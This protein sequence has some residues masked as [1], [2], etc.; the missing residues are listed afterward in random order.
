MVSKDGIEQSSVPYGQLVYSQ[1]GFHS[2]NLPKLPL[3]SGMLLH[4]LPMPE[5]LP[6]T[7]MGIDNLSSSVVEL[8]YR[9][10]VLAYHRNLA[11]QNSSPVRLIFSIPAKPKLVRRPRQNSNHMLSCVVQNVTLC[12]SFWHWKPQHSTVGLLDVVFTN[13]DRVSQHY[14]SSSLGL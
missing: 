12:N 8:S 7:R 1:P 13:I 11:I 4:K 2:L 6:D 5:F 3:V 14:P 9:E 10:A